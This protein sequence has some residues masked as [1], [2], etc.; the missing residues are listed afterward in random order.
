MKE[1]LKSIR[2]EEDIEM[3]N[4]LKEEFKQAQAM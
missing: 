2:D 1:A 3:K 4:L